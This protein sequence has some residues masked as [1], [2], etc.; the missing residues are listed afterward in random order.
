MLSGCEPVEGLLLYKEVHG[1]ISLSI[2]IHEIHDDFLLTNSQMVLRIYLKTCLSFAG[3][4]P[5]LKMLW[6]L[7][8]K[9]RTPLDLGK[10]L[11]SLR[12]SRLNLETLHIGQPFGV[13]GDPIVS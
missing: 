5:S 8:E 11:S 7:H 3:R 6:S 1:H 4:G 10:Y 9:L 2:I 12:I 13:I